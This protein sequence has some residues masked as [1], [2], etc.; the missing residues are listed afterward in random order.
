M[1]SVEEALEILL[2]NLPERKVEQV[3]FQEALG[4][5]LAE[6]LIATSDIPPFYRSSMDGY[7]VLAADV[8]ECAR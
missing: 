7:A 8:G 4:R 3:P 6:D 1:I 2:S 5:V